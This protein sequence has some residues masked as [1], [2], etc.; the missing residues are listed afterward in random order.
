MLQCWTDATQSFRGKNC[1]SRM[2]YVQTEGCR[3][4][5]RKIL[6][7]L[8]FSHL[9]P[10]GK[11]KCRETT[12]LGLTFLPGVTFNLMYS[13][14]IPGAPQVIFDLRGEATHSGPRSAM[15]A[16]KNGTLRWRCEEALTACVMRRRPCR[17]IAHRMLI[18]RA[19]CRHHMPTVDVRTIQLK[20]YLDGTHCICHLIAYAV[21]ALHPLLHDI[22]V[23][24][25]TITCEP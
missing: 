11:T 8:M 24:H 20:R 7:G 21:E 10:L 3:N 25:L 16:R 19:L 15:V 23:N 18:P 1:D 4:V 12:L 13:K 22:S 2:S 17:V 9:S 14:I 5:P 6:K